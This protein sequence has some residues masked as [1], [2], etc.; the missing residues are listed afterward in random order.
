MSFNK[1]TGMY[2][3][4]IYLLINIVNDKKYVGQ[5]TRT[6]NQRLEEHYTKLNK[7][8]AISNAIKEYGKNNFNVVELEKVINK[9]KT[10]LQ[11][12]LNKKEIFYIK[13]YNSMVSSSGGHGYNIDLGGGQVSYFRKSVDMYDLTGNYIKT[14]ESEASAS[15]KTSIP[16][17]QISNACINN[18]VAGGYLWSFSGKELKMPKIIQNRPVYKYD[19]NGML[20]QIFECVNTIPVD[21]K[22]RNRIRNCCIGLL[23]AVDGFV[24]RYGK[25]AFDKYPVHRKKIINNHT[26][27][28]YS[29]EKQYLDTF[30]S[31]KNA[32]NIT[33]TNKDSI[34]DCCRGKCKS[35]GGYLWF[36]ADDPNQPDKSKIID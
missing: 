32:S 8:Y 28:Q 20:I 34:S 22:T 30:E 2:E 4:Y 10:E 16:F 14:F 9:S 31:I 33:H 23:Y 26:V 35:A 36:Y 27:N 1:E 17:D 25:D 24:Y 12:E 6:I 29:K 7:G 5:T 13:E 19:K 18:G 3:G 15:R 11:N 21:N